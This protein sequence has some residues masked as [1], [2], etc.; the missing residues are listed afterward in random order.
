MASTKSPT[1]STSH[2]DDDDEDSAAAALSTPEGGGS[3]E[4]DFSPPPPDSSIAGNAGR[5]NG[6]VVGGGRGGS[7]SADGLAEE[8]FDDSEFDLPPVATPTLQS[9][10]DEL[11]NDDDEF[12]IGKIMKMFFRH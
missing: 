5:S 9:I 6:V 7:S 10:L 12:E 4:R 2:F 1:E 11:Q 8:D 3:P